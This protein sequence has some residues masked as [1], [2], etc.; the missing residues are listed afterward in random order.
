[1]PYRLPEH[2][3]RAARK[4]GNAITLARESVDVSAD[5]LAAAIGV[6]RWT[7]LRWE[8]GEACAPLAQIWRIALA[9]GIAPTHI[10]QVLDD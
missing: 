8:R 2:R 1:V 4:V 5:E 6:G 3:A 7:V 9:L 10:V